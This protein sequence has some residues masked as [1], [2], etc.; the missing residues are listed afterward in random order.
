MS[1]VLALVFGGL[2]G[3]YGGT[4]DIVIQRFIEVIRA[5]PELPL[6]MALSAALPP[7]W[8]PI[9]VY[10]GITVILGVL[11]WTGLARSVRGKLLAVREEDFA[12]AAVL[13]GGSPA[14][15]IRRHLLP[16]FTSH[17][18]VSATLSI[19]NM[20]LGETALSFLG[21]GLRPPITS[22]GVLLSEAQNMN[23]VALYPWLLTPVIMVVLTV[24]AFNFLGRRAPGRR[25]P[26][27]VTAEPVERNLH[28]YIVKRS[29]RPQLILI[30]ISF[31]LGL[32]LNPL[33]LDLQKRIINQAIGHRN[34]EALLWLCG[35]FLGAVILNG[36]LKYVKQN[37]EGYISETMLRD[38]R[39][40]LYNRIL[41][42]PLPHL[43]NTSTGQLV[44]MILGEVEDLGGYFGVALSTP[45]FHGAMLIGTFGYMVY[46]NPWMALVAMVLFPVQM[47]FIRRLQKKVTAM[48]RDRVRMVRGLSD[49]IQESVSGL[50]EIYAND[51]V[52][53]RVEPVPAPAPADLQDPAEHLQ[54]QVPD[55]VDQQLPGEVRPV[56]AAAGGRLAHHQPS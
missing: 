53:L 39:S 12:T 3:Y 8:D 10:V 23:A 38:L 28:R 41:R 48:S 40:E 9:L 44:A 46:A 11:E 19:P 50:Q 34:F 13:M 21:L 43:K 20:I 18:I 16:S 24:L 15:I 49:R 42:F 54:P 32:G 6:W 30:G 47:F 36:A 26:V 22:W 27:R 33:M 17:L 56:P 45:A 37:I 1:F 4:V 51:T 5:F 55:Q 25:R 52:G 7:R 14:Y 29:L 35:A 2:S 31:V